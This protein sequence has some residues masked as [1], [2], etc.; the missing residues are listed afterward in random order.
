MWKCVLLVILYIL[1]KFV[2]KVMQADE[3]Q[4]GFSKSKVAQKQHSHLLPFAQGLM[5]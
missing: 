3:L 5:E 2:R 4:R 1:G